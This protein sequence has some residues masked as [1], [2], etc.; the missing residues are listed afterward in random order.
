MKITIIGAGK[1]GRG[2]L[3]RLVNKEAEITFID[4][5]KELVNKLRNNSFKISFFG[6]KWPETIISDYKIYSWEE[7]DNINADLIFVSVGGINLTDVGIELKKYVKPGQK[8]IVAENASNPAKKLYE[9]IGVEGVLIAE[10]TVFCTTVNDGE[11]N[12]N[13]ECYPYLQY[14]AKS[15]DNIA[16]GLTNIKPID[17]FDS[18]LDRKLFTYNSAACIIAYLG[19]LKGY[20]VFGEAANDPEI[21]GMLD[22]NYELVNKA[23]CLKFGYDELDQKE[24]A[25]LSRNKFTDKTIVDSVARNGREPQRKIT[26]HERIVGIMMLLDECGLDTTILEKTLAAALL[27]SSKDDTSWEEIKNSNSYEEILTKY[28]EISKN[29]PIF[30]RIINYANKFAKNRSLN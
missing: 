3:A 22:Q 12:I 2:F 9:A 25:L 1:T 28:C 20:E 14:N 26:R 8:I 7:I 23:M 19:Y 30:N 27:F 29:N 21:L 17:N 13:S 4:K 5:N 16:L 15:I 11:I 18:F 24:F 10:S 6:N